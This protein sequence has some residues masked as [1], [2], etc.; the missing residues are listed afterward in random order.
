MPVNIDSLESSIDIDKL[1]FDYFRYEKER[2]R[3]IDRIF[4]ENCNY[5]IERQADFS[6]ECN[7]R[8]YQIQNVGLF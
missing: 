6:F 3:E 7:L 5:A 1:P 8:R 4:K 2:K